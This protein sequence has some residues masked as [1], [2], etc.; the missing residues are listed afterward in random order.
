MM[1]SLSACNW[2]S[3]S[4]AAAELSAAQKESTRLPNYPE[5]CRELI[6]LGAKRGEPVSQA[7]ERAYLRAN[8]KNAQITWCGR[9]YDK[10]QS[11]RASLAD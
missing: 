8:A 6:D 1:I 10:L 9:W 7:L 5:V 11:D 2:A 4:D 3:N